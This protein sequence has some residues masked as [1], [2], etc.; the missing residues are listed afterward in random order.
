MTIRFLEEN[1]LDEV[2]VRLAR[3]QVGL[4][5][6]YLLDTRISYPF[7]PSR[8]IYIGM[9]ESRQNT[10]GNRLRD[11]ASGQSGNPGLTNFISRKGA[12]FTHLP[13]ETL[14]AVGKHTIPE[15]ESIFLMDFLSRHGCYPICNN[16]AGVELAA[17]SCQGDVVIE[18]SFFE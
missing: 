15:L 10:V 18:W 16:Q 4:Y 2:S 11:H 3:G 1:P 17:N 12:R 7:R 5:F 14:R 8:L 9:S 13:E 6:I